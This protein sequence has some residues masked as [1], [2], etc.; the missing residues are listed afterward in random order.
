MSV[1]SYDVVI[2]LPSTHFH[3]PST[4]SSVSPIQTCFSPPYKLLMKFYQGRNISL[5]I[6]HLFTK[7]CMAYILYIGGR[8]YL[9]TVLINILTMTPGIPGINMLLCSFI[10]IW[11]CFSS[12]LWLS[13]LQISSSFNLSNKSL[14]MSFLS[15][16]SL[17]PLNSLVVT[18][19]KP[20]RITTSFHLYSNNLLASLF[21]YILSQTDKRTGDMQHFAADSCTQKSVFFG[22]SRNETLKERLNIP[23][24]F[25][26]NRSEFLFRSRVH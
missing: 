5:K 23:N 12:L 16:L 7:K 2:W 1:V 10:T 11:A 19:M 24:M 14:N 4:P 3:S 6:L 17:K 20:Q 25:G 13:M 26:I 22:E 21:W 9:K 15:F 18:K 8:V